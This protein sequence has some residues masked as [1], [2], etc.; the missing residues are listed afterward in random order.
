MMQLVRSK[1]GYSC[2]RAS[3]TLFALLL[4]TVYSG[5][6]PTPSTITG[7]V[8]FE[9]KPISTG[10]IVFIS[11]GGKVVSGNIFVGDYHVTGVE[12]GPGTTVSISSHQPS[13]LMRPPTEDGGD[14]PQRK[15]LEYTPIPGRY[16]RSETSGLT[17]NVVEGEQTLD[18]ALQ[19]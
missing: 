12:T 17:C 11:P 18:F 3:V 5:C 7:K 15:T 13:P 2:V 1:R 14:V 19:P 4:L 8:T 16:R 10:S 6:G 9:G